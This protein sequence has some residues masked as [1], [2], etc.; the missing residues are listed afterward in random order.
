MGKKRRWFGS[1]VEGKE[2]FLGGEVEWLYKEHN[3]SL[4]SLFVCIHYCTLVSK[5]I[6][7]SIWRT[8]SQDCYVLSETCKYFYKSLDWLCDFAFKYRDYINN[9]Y[10]IC[11]TYIELSPKKHSQLKENFINSWPLHG[12]KSFVI[13][14]SEIV[15]QWLDKNCIFICD[16]VSYLFRWF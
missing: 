13:E 6:R 9:K 14:K 3:N 1:L 10:R 15:G 4:F 11:K 8:V 5:P 12:K 2:T 16:E 7:K